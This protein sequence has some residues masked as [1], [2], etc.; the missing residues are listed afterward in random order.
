MGI[1]WLDLCKISG[2][3]WSQIV[4]VVKCSRSH[5]LH[6]FKQRSW[7]FISRCTISL[8]PS[9]LCWLVMLLRQLDHGNNV[10]LSHNHTFPSTDEIEGGGINYSGETECTSD[11]GCVVIKYIS[12]SHTVRTLINSPLVTTTR[13]ANL[14]LPPLQV[15]NPSQSQNQ[16]P[17]QLK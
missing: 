2:H 6:D 9:W 12:Q 10:Y 3:I 13:N 11:A 5:T 1:T 4:P 15:L 17:C 14:A 16:N 8:L 7:I